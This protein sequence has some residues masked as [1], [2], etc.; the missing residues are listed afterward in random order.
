MGKI[1]L[2]R[3]SAATLVE[4]IIAL[5]IIMA[6]FGITAIVLI[7]T[8]TTSFSVKKIKADNF[9]NQFANETEYAKSFFDDQKELGSFIVQKKIEENRFDL[10]VEFIKFSVFDR[11]GK[12][13]SYQNRIFKSK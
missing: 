3:L 2:I 5:V 9:I 6:V 10:S 1:K 12:L 7:Q 13:I 11:N 4:T 8:N